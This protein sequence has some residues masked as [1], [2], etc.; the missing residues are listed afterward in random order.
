VTAVTVIGLQAVGLILIVALLIIPP[1]AARF[2]TSR[3]TSMLIVSAAIGAAS[4]CI[5]AIASALVPRL[6]AGAIIVVTAASAFLVSVIF[7]HR[8]GIIVRSVARWRLN[9]RV[10]RQHI[11]RAIFEILESRESEPAAGGIVNFD[12]LLRKRSWSPLRLRRLLRVARRDRLVTLDD[13]HAALT[14]RGLREA[15][16]TVRNHRLWEI[17]LITHADV[18]PSHVD[19]DADMIEHVLSPALIARLE[20]LLAAQDETRAI[21][22]PHEL[23]AAPG[24]GSLA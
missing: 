2:W 8:R 18:A 3:L 6:P 1:A 13:H 4:G 9:R 24:T 5:G 22:S 15:N 19:R 12:D 16:R 10:G 17:Y 11:V 14:D 20:A 7:G 23:Q 21:P